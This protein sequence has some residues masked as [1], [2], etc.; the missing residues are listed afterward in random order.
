MNHISR[1]LIGSMVVLLVIAAY[2][3]ANAMPTQNEVNKARAECHAHKQRV[4]T[5][6]GDSTQ[7]DPR[8]A[9]ARSLWESA[10]ARANEL[11]DERDG[12]PSLMPEDR[13]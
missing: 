13:V 6:E 10:C 5:L 4:K 1:Y 3:T 8:V 11:M 7:G 9:E 2:S 12:C